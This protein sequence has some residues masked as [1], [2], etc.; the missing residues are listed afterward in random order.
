MGLPA[1]KNLSAALIFKESVHFDFGEGYPEGW[2]FWD[3]DECS[4]C[5]KVL[6]SNGGEEQHCDIDDKSE[7]E[8]YVNGDGP[9]MNY[10]YPLDGE[11]TFNKYDFDW[12]AYCKDEQEAAKRLAYLPLCLVRIGAW[13]DDNWALALTGGGMNLAWQIAEAHIRLG[14]L[15]PLDICEG[16]PDFAGQGY[17]R[18]RKE[19]LAACNRSLWYATNNISHAKRELKR[20]RE[21]MKANDE[22]RKLNVA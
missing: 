20:R 9:M 22:R 6:M 2:E 14:F 3:A 17:T 13:D 8:G 1:A 19:I 15:P 5:G 11:H 16:L 21:Y 10:Y 4:E 12:G 18:R 7:C